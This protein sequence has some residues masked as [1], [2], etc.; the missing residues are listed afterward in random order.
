MSKSQSFSQEQ[1]ERRILTVRGYQVMID[2][3]LTEM[4]HGETRVLNQAVKRNIERFPEAFMFQ[5][6]EEETAE[7]VARG[8]R[9]KFA[10][11]QSQTAPSRSQNVT[12]NVSNSIS[13]FVSATRGCQSQRDAAKRINSVPKHV[14]AAYFTPAK[15]A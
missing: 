7:W 9:S 6:T 3:D 1:I 2:R 10:N 15:N 11:A 12:L 5:L 13:S 8:D 4:Y 14:Q